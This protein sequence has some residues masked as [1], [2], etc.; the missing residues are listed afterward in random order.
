MITDREG[1]AED[2]T[3]GM[4]EPIGG[5]ERWNQTR[6]NG[7]KVRKWE[8]NSRKRFEASSRMLEELRTEFRNSNDILREIVRRQEKTARNE[9]MFMTLQLIKPGM[10]EYGKIKTEMYNRIL[11]NTGSGGGNETMI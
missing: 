4:E 10:E 7:M 9:Y 5:T 3:G 6:V 2:V 1:T 11:P 8:L